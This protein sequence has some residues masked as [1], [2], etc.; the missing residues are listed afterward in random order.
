MAFKYQSISKKEVGT[1]LSEINVTPLVDVMLVLLII[2]MVTAPMMQSGI[3]VNLPQAE[4]QTTPA[5]EGLTIS[6]SSDRYIHIQDQVINQMLLEDSIKAYFTGIENPI[7]Y[8]RADDALRYGYV[9]S[10]MDTIKKAGVEKV[11]LIVD[12]LLEKDR[13]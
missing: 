3:S 5:E 9:I 1:S 12:P 10:I 7:V 11:S 13:K 2:F 8:I 4:T 6:I